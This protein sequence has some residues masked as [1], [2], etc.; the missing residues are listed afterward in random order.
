MTED[1]F[2][3]QVSSSLQLECEVPGLPLTLQLV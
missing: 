1:D 2:I 3:F